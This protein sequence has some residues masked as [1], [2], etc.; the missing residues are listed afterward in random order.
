MDF[1]ALLNSI[2]EFIKE[3]IAG[4]EAAMAGV[5]ETPGYEKAENFPANF[6]KAE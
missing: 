2:I 5:V 1:R 6:P 3:L 4:I